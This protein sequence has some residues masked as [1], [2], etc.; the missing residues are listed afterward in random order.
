M[1]LSDLGVR[2]RLFIGFGVLL[3]LLAVECG[4]TVSWFRRIDALQ[5]AVYEDIGPRARAANRLERAIL[6]HAV[7]LRNY[8]LTHEP[9]YLR[10]RAE[11]VEQTRST[12]Q[13]IDALARRPE[14]RA[15]VSEMKPAAEAHALAAERFL[16]LL[17]TGASADRLAPAEN[18]V[19]AARE[20]LFQLAR[21]FSDYQQRKLEDTTARVGAAQARMAWGLP[22]L[23]LLIVG[24]ILVTALVVARAVADPVRALVAAARS[25]AKGDYRRAM[26]LDPDAAASREELPQPH[27]NELRE[28]AGAVAHSAATLQQRELELAADVRLSRVVASAFAV[29]DLADEALRLIASHVRAELGVVYVLDDESSTLRRAASFAFGGHASALALGE[30]IP[31]QAAAQKST[32][33]VRDIPADTP[34]RLRLGFN[35]PHPRGILAVPVLHR[36][37][38]RGVILLATLREFREEGV[39]FVEHAANL[40]APSLENAVA[41]QAVVRFRGALQQKNQELNVRNEELQARREQI[42]EK[43]EELQ[44]QNE[45]LQAQREEI[46]TQNEELQTQRDELLDQGERLREAAKA[47]EQADRRKDEFLAT[48]GHELRNPLAAIGH[49]V[50]VLE[51]RI[52]EALGRQVG[53]ISRQERQLARLVDDLLDVSRISHGKLALR[54]RPV[55]MGQILRQAAESSRSFIESRRHELSLSVGEGALAV[56]GDPTRLEQVVC[57]LLHNAA[58]FTEPRGSIT[59]G[60]E[61]DGDRVVLRVKDTG[62]GIDGELLPRVFEFFTQGE[63]S[64]FRRNGLGVGLSLVRDLVEMHG[65]RVEAVSDGPQRG[66]EFVVSLPRLAQPTVERADHVVPQPEGLSRPRPLRVMVVDDNP[67]VAG[68]LAELVQEWGHEVEIERSGKGALDA[69][70]RRAS[71]AVLVDIGLPDMNGYEVARELRRRSAPTACARLIAMTGHGREEDRQRATDAGFDLFF[72]K[73]D[74]GDELRA[75][76]AELARTSVS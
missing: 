74:P 65:G 31:G 2:Q 25:L 75:A 38:P 45:E 48:L 70:A 40:L 9:R 8:G 1:K 54:K 49:A 4:F 69:A 43:N 18:E 60:V 72:L 7:A 35:D 12:L 29:D 24:T 27:G 51:K 22:C 23:A 28:L 52:P 53:I 21:R 63:P 39:R 15:I 6:M 41:H 16:E 14:G 26:A 55:D 13:D 56:E 57:N 58:K 36:E 64:P 44:T 11:S 76:L 68:S 33:H 32:I 30:G 50:Q 59:A 42:Q 3:A 47:R 10:A 20:N 61:A 37:K 62:V 46:Q 5:E 17:R 66:S 19:A 73:G 34:F 67:D 71:D